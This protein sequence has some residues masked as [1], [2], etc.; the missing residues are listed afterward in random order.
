[1]RHKVLLTPPWGRNYLQLSALGVP[2]VLFALLALGVLTGGAGTAQAAD[3]KN[4]GAPSAI[5]PKGMV[6]DTATLAR[7]M[8]APITVKVMSSTAS[9]T[10][11]PAQ[12]Q[13]AL[14]T[15]TV[16]T[17]PAAAT[18]TGVVS[19]TV[20]TVT[21]TPVSQT[22]RLDSTK[23]NALLAPLAK[24]AKTTVR[25]AKVD[26]VNGQAVIVRE[27]PGLDLDTTSALTMTVAAALT[28]ARSVTL[29]VRVTAPTITV[30]QVQPFFDQWAAMLTNGFT[31]NYNGKSWRITAAMLTQYMRVAPGDQK[32]TYQLIGIRSALFDRL[33]SVSNEVN[34]Q[35]T[36]SRFRLVKGV[37]TQ[38]AVAHGG[39]TVDKD[40]SL[41]TA[42]AA[43]AAGQ[44]QAD[45]V[46][47]VQ[48][49]PSDVPAPQSVST[50]DL[51]AKS[52]TSYVGSSPE[53]AHNV[54]F[55][56]SLLD[57]AL[58]PPGA[59]FDT[60]GTM[61]PLTLAAGFK[62]GFGIVSDG[63]NVTTVPAEAGGICQ[64]ATTLFHSVFWAGLP[65]TERHYHSYWI[66]SYGRPPDGLQGLDAT[67]SPPEK[68]F[69]WVNNTGNWILVKAAAA[70][71]S[72]T[73]QL[74]GTKQPW[75][76]KVDKPVITKVV[77]TDRTPIYEKSDM[78]AA[79]TTR[80]VEHAQPGFDSDIR[81]R[82]YNAQGALL[83]DWHAVSHYLPSHERY[84]VGTKGK[85]KTGAAPPAKPKATPTPAPA[86][87][88]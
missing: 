75:T 62:M 39:R 37:I 68:N 78:I 8:Q 41:A 71:G 26:L 50:P 1:M 51:L 80:Q 73:F 82:V 46:V 83:D 87:K 21:A 12:L 63:K 2:V 45:L 54:E 88:P 57:G 81:R 13:K 42:M 5:G 7:L 61:G 76:V 16:K 18:A 36:N 59:E 15:D 85:G 31:Y 23:F 40:A 66:A 3:P 64:V 55:G 38:T 58:V 22:V 79:G 10:L 35:V 65:I 27:A 9:L 34:I 29:P 28:P 84:V 53:R 20:G 30:A 19:G 56:T 72:V 70:K 14:V 32:G 69:R 77:K 86:K 67:V 49:S 43:L 60:T 25:N 24:Q 74:W 47:N 17:A 48:A 4:A 33:W 44:Y 6:L 52:T 11:S